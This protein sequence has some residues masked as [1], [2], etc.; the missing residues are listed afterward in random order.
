LAA[1]DRQPAEPAGADFVSL[2]S[3]RKVFVGKIDIQK[4]RTNFHPELHKNVCGELL[5]DLKKVRALKA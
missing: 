5:A 4:F 3:D 2:D 1:A